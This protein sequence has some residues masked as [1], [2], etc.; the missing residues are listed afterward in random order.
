MKTHFKMH[1]S[2]WSRTDEARSRTL[3]FK[4]LR[5]AKRDRMEAK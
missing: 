2:D 3:D 5:R 4:Q 1:R